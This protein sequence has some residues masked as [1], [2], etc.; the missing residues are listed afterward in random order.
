MY[1][2]FI[3]FTIAHAEL[4]SIST[5]KDGTMTT[6]VDANLQAITYGLGDLLVEKGL[7]VGGTEKDAGDGNIKLTGNIQAEGSIQANSAIS[8]ASSID[9]SVVN[10]PDI[11]TNKITSTDPQDTIDFYPTDTGLFAENTHDM[12]GTKATMS[13]HTP[14]LYISGQVYVYNGVHV[15]DE[16]TAA[17]KNFRV[18]HDGNAYAKKKLQ[19]DGDLNTQHIRASKRVYAND[20]L[21]VHKSLLS[22]GPSTFRENVVMQRYLDIKGYR[23]GPESGKATY[24][25]YLRGGYW[26]DET[27]IKYNTVAP[28]SA[29]NNRKISLHATHGLL[30]GGFIGLSDRRI[31][32]DI[33]P[34]PDNHALNIIRRLDT[35]YYN[36]RDVVKKGTRRTIGFIAQEVKEHIPEAVNINKGFIPSE[37]RLIEPKWLQVSDTVWSFKVDDLESSGTYNFFVETKDGDQEKIITTENDGKTFLTNTRFEKIFLY[38][39]EVDDLHAIDKDKIWAISYAALQQVDKNQQI[40]QEKVKTLEETVAALSERL[41]ALE[42]R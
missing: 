19:V 21:D 37:M 31:K 40:L 27:S 25:I 8:T 13:I 34:V 28:Y 5:C 14:K 10:S 18:G 16:F 2:L 17:D 35:K 23:T 7:N 3:L 22:T 38:G 11:A 9:A 30:A 4:Q 24:G 39:K 1:F 6:W 36:Y 29:F 15:D 20:G 41:A 33:V 26:N 12:T 42:A 32:K